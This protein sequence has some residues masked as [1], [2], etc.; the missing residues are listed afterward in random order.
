MNKKKILIIEDEFII[1]DVLANI[2]LSA[3]YEV[4]GIADTVKEGLEMVAE[5]A[6][7]F[8]LL[9]IFLKGKLTGIDMAQRL[10][11]MNVPFIYISAN[12]NQKVL[13]AAKVT[14]P[15]G[16]VV[17]PFRDKDVLTALEIAVYRH[18]NQLE[19]GSR[20][21]AVLQKKV[22]EILASTYSWE[23]KMLQMSKTLQPYIPFE[24]LSFG[25][26]Q[27]DEADFY[28]LGFTR[29]G[30]DE[31]QLIGANELMM[32]TNHKKHE[33]AVLK[34]NDLTGLMATW[35]DD[36]ELEDLLNKPS[37]KKVYTE[38]YQLRSHLSFPIELGEG[39]YV[40]FSF[41]SRRPDAYFADHLVLCNRFQSLVA[42][43]TMKMLQRADSPLLSG[44]T[45]YTI[46]HPAATAETPNPFNGIIGKSHLLL[47]VFD[48]VIQVARVDASVL[49]LGES[50]TGKE[51]IAE[52]IHALSLRNK[53]PF[54]RINCAALPTSLIDS[55]LFGHEKGAFTGAHERKIGRFEQAHTGTIFLD[56]IGELPLES[57][58]KLLRVLQEKEIERIGGRSTIK[59]DVRIIA[60]TNRDLTKEVAE[61]RFRL[62][63]FYRINVFP[64]VMPPLRERK[65]DISDLAH[66]FLNIYSRKIGKMVRGITPQVLEN[67]KQYS[68]PGNIRELEN[69]VERNVL[70]TREEMITSMVLPTQLEQSS[71]AVVADPA[72][73]TMSEGERA[74]I[75]AALR[76]CNGKVW[77]EGGAASLL[78]LPPTTLNSKM[79]KLG[80][81][82]DF[83]N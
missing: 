41:Y 35:Y 1:A 43:F 77:G 34:A 49:I 61:G 72:I 33:L 45:N 65:E 13:D 52:R 9:D 68:W 79:K 64:I 50:G 22:A 83:G 26:K 37:L 8:V 7:D 42:N 38:I 25:L 54:V 63:L 56:E 16:F 30:Y 23:L 53:K 40:W 36:E 4:C 70:L 59:I 32:A 48:Q 21:V 66:H 20:Q 12:S 82:K 28:E 67:M 2:L 80:I 58:S 51:K 17:K 19:N 76:R 11:E 78:N 44:R 81:R 15:Y 3:G 73:S 6:P 10:G 62:D 69:L 57:Q 71:T 47:T 46:K 75:M 24:F 55:E 39:K 29:V 14:S 31:Y 18:E 74:H 5:L 27:E 60:A